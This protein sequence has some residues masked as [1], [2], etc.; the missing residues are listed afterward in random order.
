MNAPYSHSKIICSTILISILEPIKIM[1]IIPMINRNLRQWKY[2]VNLL[3]V[4]RPDYSLLVQCFCIRNSQGISCVFILNESISMHPYILF[5]KVMPCMYILALYV[6][7]CPCSNKKR[8]TSIPGQCSLALH[9]RMITPIQISIR[10]TYYSG[11]ESHKKF[12]ESR[13]CH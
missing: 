10:H 11:Q 6:P 3:Y 12:S 5:Y 13:D 4:S 8:K 2:L 9:F 1:F 7:W